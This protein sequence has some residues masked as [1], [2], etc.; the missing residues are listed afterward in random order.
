M[1]FSRKKNK[2]F[3]YLSLPPLFKPYLLS[4]QNLSLQNLPL[5]SNKKTLIK[6]ISISFPRDT[7]ISSL[8]EEQATEEEIGETIRHHKAIIANMKEQTIPLSRKLR[9]LQRSKGFIKRHRELGELKQSKQ[10]KDLLARYSVYMER[11]RKKVKFT[12]F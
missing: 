1:I 12:K 11:V 8:N 7:Q 2:S 3:V 5:I 9:V 4:L 6:I 10:P